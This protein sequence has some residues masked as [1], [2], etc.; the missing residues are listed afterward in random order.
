MWTQDTGQLLPL[1][2]WKAIDSKFGFRTPP[3]FSCPPDVYYRTLQFK[4][5]IFLCLNLCLIFT[6]TFYKNVIR[7]FSVTLH[8]VCVANNF[9]GDTIFRDVLQCGVDK[10]NKINRTNRTNGIF[11][12]ALTT[13]TRSQ[14]IAVCWNLNDSYWLWWAAK[15][16]EMYLWSEFALWGW[17]FAT[18]PSKS[19]QFWVPWPSSHIPWLSTLNW[20]SVWC[21]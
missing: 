3:F 9:Y 16:F 1:S 21:D 10:T 14:K 20:I 17:A 6:R 8:N 4:V 2:S 7:D 18:D 5:A 15:S 19:N 11:I 13:Q 12:A